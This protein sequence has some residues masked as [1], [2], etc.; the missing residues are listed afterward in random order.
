MLI[1][2]VGAS[3]TGKSTIENEICKMT[4][5]KKIVSWTTRAPR[6]GE[7]NGV[8]YYFTNNEE[9]L[10]ELDSMAE[11]EEYSFNR[12]YG[13]MKMQYDNDKELVTVLTPHGVRQIK[14]NMPELKM[15]VVYVT[16]P[17][18]DK[19]IRYINRCGDNLSYSDM[20]ELGARIERDFGM[21]KGFE[22]EADFVIDNPDG[23]RI[24]E[25]VFQ[26]MSKYRKEKNT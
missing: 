24:H 13:T 9:F 21:F 14:K 12:Y 26:I 3:G 5:F 2:L 8:D 20:S 1:V 17:L 19:A 16:A 7:V 23:T 22:D 6:P 18:K 25:L 15:F 10:K 11:W 4:D